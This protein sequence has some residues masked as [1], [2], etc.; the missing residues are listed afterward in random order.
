MRDILEEMIVR[1]RTLFDDNKRYIVDFKLQETES[2]YHISV[3]STL[4]DQP[5]AGR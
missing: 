5:D 2:N 4:A 1:K 3:M